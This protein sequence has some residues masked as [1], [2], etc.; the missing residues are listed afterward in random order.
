MPSPLSR[1][2]GAEERSRRNTRR[3]ASRRHRRAKP[4]HALRCLSERRRGAR[5]RS[6]STCADRS[7]RP[8]GVISLSA[9]SFIPA[10][11]SPFP[12]PSGDAPTLGHW[13]RA[14]HAP[15][16]RHRACH[17]EGCL[18]SCRSDPPLFTRKPSP[19]PAPNREGLL[20][21]FL[22]RC[23]SAPAPTRVPRVGQQRRRSAI[24]GPSRL[25]PND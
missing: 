23:V 14:T 6:A 25:P 5:M 3:L 11:A 18:G 13:A 21:S 4:C 12:A 10:K 1:R 8:R 15:Q 20:K 24:P 7:D 9:H 2:I 22:H 17:V 16:T 19:F